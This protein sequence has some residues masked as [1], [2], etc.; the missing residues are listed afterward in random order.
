MKEVTQ[1]SC[2]VALFSNF[3]R[4]LIVY[5]V[6]REVSEEAMGMVMVLASL[7]VKAAVKVLVKLFFQ[8]EIVDLLGVY[9]GVEA[10]VHSAEPHD[11][12]MCFECVLVTM[13]YVVVSSDGLAWSAFRFVAEFQNRMECWTQALQCIDRIDNG[14]LRTRDRIRQTS[15]PCISSG[16]RWQGEDYPIEALQKLVEL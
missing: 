3:R 15:S 4:Y 6:I 14:S 11:S 8:D 12:K 9:S 7:S 1:A 16:Q 10:H 13:V 5:D 2:L